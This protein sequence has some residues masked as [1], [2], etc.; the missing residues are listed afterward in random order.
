MVSTALFEENGAIVVADTLCHGGGYFRN[1][2]DETGDPIEAIAV[3]YLEQTSC[4]RMIDGF[5]KRMNYLRTVMSEYDVDAVILKKLLYCDIWGGE[6]YLLRQEAKRLNFPLLTLDREL[7]GG[8][9]G[10]LRTRVQAFME[11]ISNMDKKSH[12]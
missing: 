9:T 6:N 1:I 3:G 10:Q 2:I 12:Q 11:R 8:G 5:Y 7:Y 4:P